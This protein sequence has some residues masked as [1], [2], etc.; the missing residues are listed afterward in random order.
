MGFMNQ[1]KFLEQYTYSLENDFTSPSGEPA[2]WAPA[3]PKHWGQERAKILLNGKAGALALSPDDKLIAVGVEEDIHI[4][5]V[6]THQRLEV[7]RGHTGVIGIVQFSASLVHNSE[8]Q[9]FPHYMLVSQSDTENDQMIILWELDEHGKFVPLGERRE[10]TVDSD[11]L[12][13]KALQPLMSQ[14][15]ADYGWDPSEKA[16]GA[17]DQDVR[18][19]FRHAIKI[20]E[21][22]YRL[23]FEGQLASFGSPAFSPDGKTMIYLSQNESTQSG[24][25]EAAYLPCVNLWDVE[26]RSLRHQLLGH[27]DAIMCTSMSLDNL[28]VASI[29]WDG[30]ARVWD[31]NSGACLR[32]LG[33][34]GGQLWCGAF[35]PDGKYLA[36]S[37]GSP[38]TYIYVYEVG[39][40][41]PVSHF[42]GFHRWAR[43]LAWSPD[44]TMIACGADDSELFILDPY[45]GEE[46]MR[47]RLAFEDPLMR[48]FAAIRRVQFVD[49]G[50]KLIFRITEGTV[51]MYDFES[52]TKQQ[53]T[54]RTEDKIERCPGSGIV[55]SSDSRFLVVPDVDDVLRLWDL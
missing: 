36:L 4:F 55:C 38:K 3:H 30:T 44:G 18:N 7:L 51:E 43:S 10:K 16:I 17:L 22:E 54:R 2:A 23:C 47:W 40:G 52:N 11:T 24:S 34:F 41:R 32:V 50:R 14:L 42:E 31:T 20:H 21:Q 33:P 46:R 27:T 35:S 28:L 12:A 5:H 48:G 25:R 26:S 19:A 49:G 45:T 6:A 13:V 37:Q 9:N 8:N 39:T 1:R 29:S 53:F 15:I